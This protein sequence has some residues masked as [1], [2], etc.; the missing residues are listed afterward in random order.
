MVCTLI[1]AGTRWWRWCS[2][3]ASPGWTTTSRNVAARRRVKLVPATLRCHRPYYISRRPHHA[4]PKFGCPVVFVS[5]TLIIVEW[6][7]NTYI[8]NI[9]IWLDTCIYI[10]TDTRQTQTHKRQNIRPQA[11]YIMRNHTPPYY[12]HNTI[13]TFH[14]SRTYSY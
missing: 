10:Q 9:N 4:A 3:A 8:T 5:T 1:V 7:N 13:D 14:W 2:T 12:T 11:C 6:L